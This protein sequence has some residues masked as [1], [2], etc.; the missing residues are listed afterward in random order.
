MVR[1][2][3]AGVLLA[4]VLAAG[5]HA[6]E[7]PQAPVWPDTALARTEALALLQTLNANL[8]SHD[9]ATLTLERWCSAHGMA[10]PAQVTAERVHG[11]A[12]A[13][14]DDLRA[15]LGIAAGEPVA[16]RRVALRCGG[17]TLSEAENWYVPSRLTVAMNH[18]LETTDTPFGKVV[19]PLHF[20]RRTLSAEL[21]WSPLPPGWEQAAQLPADRPGA[22]PI[23]PRLLQHRA[24]L[25]DGSGR[26][27]SALIE[28]Y[29]D[30]V[31]AFEPP[32]A[33][34]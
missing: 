14:P 2:G 28:T 9:S 3:S 29:T 19:R 13:L 5:V 20:R 33:R 18:T 25:F 32:P 27:F 22:L 4:G 17:R 30:Q 6:D 12:R 34:P 21:L 24:L 1:H 10:S 11:P 7:A 31:L 26:P 16:Y 23:P 15:Q 8:L